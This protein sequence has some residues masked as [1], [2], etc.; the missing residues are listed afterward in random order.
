LLTV[1][2]MRWGVRLTSG[3]TLDHEE[4]VQAQLK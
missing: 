3:L 2:T 1:R 4:M